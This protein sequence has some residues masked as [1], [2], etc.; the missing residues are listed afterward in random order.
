MIVEV[1]CVKLFVIKF[2]VNWSHLEA[3]YFKIGE[4]QSW[5]QAFS[6]KR[7]STS[8][9][10]GPISDPSWLDIGYRVI[11]HSLYR[12]EHNLTFTLHNS[13]FILHNLI[14]WYQIL[15][16]ST[17]IKYHHI[18]STSY[19]SLINIVFSTSNIYQVLTI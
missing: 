17:F 18:F 16:H 15:S 6:E 8:D 13:T 3:I 10:K 11:R 2:W 4:N 5:K 12:I 1:Y 19:C 7:L 14:F 9:Y